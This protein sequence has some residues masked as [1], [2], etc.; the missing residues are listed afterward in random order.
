MLKRRNFY[1]KSLC[2]VV[3]CPYLRSSD[4][5]QLGWY[6]IN[7]CDSSS[8]PSAQDPNQPNNRVA[9][10]NRSTSVARRVLMVKANCS[11]SWRPHLLRLLCD[12]ESVLETYHGYLHVCT[13]LLRK[14]QAHKHVGQPNTHT[15]QY[16]DPCRESRVAATPC[17]HMAHTSINHIT[18]EMLKAAYERMPMVTDQPCSRYNM[19]FTVPQRGIHQGGSDR[20]ITYHRFYVTC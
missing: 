10:R 16:Q 6:G 4:D 7:D 17:L 14:R 12:L 9:M 3:I 13:A 11:W 15:I 2:P 20:H 1:K 18:C 5:R 8:D 19:L